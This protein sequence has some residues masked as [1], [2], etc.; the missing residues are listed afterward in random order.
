M[1]DVKSHYRPA[2][3]EEVSARIKTSIKQPNQGV[4][5]AEESQRVEN[6]IEADQDPSLLPSP[7]ILR[8]QRS[9]HLVLRVKDFCLQ[10]VLLNLLILPSLALEERCPNQLLPFRQPSLATLSIGRIKL[11]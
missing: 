4:Q 1:D 6:R 5:G 10:L 3:Q 2:T 9:S 8:S 11:S 7:L